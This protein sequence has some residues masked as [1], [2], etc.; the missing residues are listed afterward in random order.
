MAKQGSFR[1]FDWV[2]LGFV[3][4]ISA[5]GVLQIYSATIS[6]KFAE[7][8]IYVKQIEWLIAG[9]VLMF[10]ISRIDYH[11]FLE[12]IHWVY[13]A[14]IGSLLAVAVIGVRLLGAKR[15]IRVPGLGLFQPSEWV[16]IVLIIALARY[17][18]SLNQRDVTW[19]DIFKAGLIAGVPFLLVVKQP[20]LGTSLTYLPA[21]I[22]GLFLGGINYK[23]VGVIVLCIALVLPVAWKFGMKQY[24]KDR[25]TNFLHPENDPK[26]TGYQ[27]QQSLIAVGNGGIFGKGVAGGTQTQGMFLPVTHTDFI[28][29]AFAEEHGFVGATAVL[30]LYFIVLM[31]LIQNAQTAP[32]RA[33]TLIIMGV[34]AVLVFH[35]MVNIGMVVGMMPVTG[36][37]LPLMSYGGSS[38][39]F[40]FLALG[41]VM[42]IR[43][44]RF[45]N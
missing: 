45:V 39:L 3:M 37:P 14:S 7:G 1:D 4:A 16:K 41:I 26:G 28:F 17:I 13:L 10:A 24:Q 34:V 23:Q 5:L 40:M 25:L 21:L 9:M 6:T 18:A 15:W 32:D 11:I 35:I 43:M 22:L 29:A 19:P 42:N 33:G 31:R 30:L 2:L 38:V 36:I 8:N 20:D 44:R 12:Y 27:I